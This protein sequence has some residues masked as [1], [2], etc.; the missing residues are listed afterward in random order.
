M[1]GEALALEYFIVLVGVD[2]VVI[3]EAG[4]GAT[5]EERMGS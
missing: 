1:D 5:V 4:R 3:G 2:K